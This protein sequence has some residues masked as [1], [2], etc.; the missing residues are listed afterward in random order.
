MRNILTDVGLMSWKPTW[1][2]AGGMAVHRHNLQTGLE[3]VFGFPGLVVVICIRLF[4]AV[5]LL[6]GI[7]QNNSIETALALLVAVTSVILVIRAPYGHSG[8]DQMILILFVTISIA[9][10]FD[11]DAVIPSMAL[12]FIAAQVCLAY[13]TSGVYKA[14]S[15]VWRSGK[16]LVNTFASETFGC[17][18]FARFLV[19]NQTVSMILV[20]GMI[21]SFG[22]ITCTLCDRRLVNNWRTFSSL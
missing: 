9:H 1:I 22:L 17:K 21:S 8:A 20:T 18:S 13:F 2:G 15:P 10:A 3:Y 7:C 6:L 12:F 5:L 14:V 16:A 19:S 11:Q 4:C